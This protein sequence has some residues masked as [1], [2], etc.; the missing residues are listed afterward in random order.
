M[1]FVTIHQFPLN[2]K[3]EMTQWPTFTVYMYTISYTNC[4]FEP[5]WNLEGLC[6]KC[7]TVLSNPS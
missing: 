7:N 4:L 3:P 6:E 1:E 2:W 5:C